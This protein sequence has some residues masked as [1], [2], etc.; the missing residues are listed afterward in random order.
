M[1]SD[2]KQM[3][4]ECGTVCVVSQ[5]AVAVKCCLCVLEAQRKKGPIGFEDPL[6]L[7]EAEVLRPDDPKLEWED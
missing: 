5:T 4:C 2:L 6:P 1:K 7:V 3:R